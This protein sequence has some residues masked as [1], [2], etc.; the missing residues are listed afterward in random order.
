MRDDIAFAHMRV[1]VDRDVGDIAHD[2]GRECRV[3][4]AHI[5]VVGRDEITAGR[6]PIL[7]VPAGN[8]QRE[9]AAEHERDRLGGA[10][11]GL[12]VID[13]SFASRRSRELTARRGSTRCWRTVS[14][15]ASAIAPDGWRL[16]GLRRLPCYA[17]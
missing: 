3:L 5:G 17:G 6:P 15:Y 13:G 1:V 12:R 8:A 11:A 4:G 10:T 16:E 14:G 2:L 7:A 9:Q